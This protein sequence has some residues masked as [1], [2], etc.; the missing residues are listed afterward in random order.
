MFVQFLS[1]CQRAH[2]ST[3]SRRNLMKIVF[4]QLLSCTFAAGG[5]ALSRTALQHRERHRFR[6]RKQRSSAASGV[7]LVLSLSVDFLRKNSTVKLH[8]PNR[9]QKNPGPTLTRL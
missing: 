4:D 6:S 3:R 7:L 2:V 8:Q 5:N 1:A 9:K